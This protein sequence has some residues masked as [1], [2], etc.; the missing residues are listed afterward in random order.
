[1]QT[2]RIGLECVAIAAAIWAALFVVG[3]PVWSLLVGRTARLS[4]TT[5]APLTGLALVEAI[6][7]YWSHAFTLDPLAYA[8]VGAGAIASVV[9]A[10]RRRVWERVDRAFLV[11]VTAPFMG[12]A[13][14]VSALFVL[15]HRKVFRLGFLSTGVLGVESDLPNYA[16]WA[17]HLRHATIHQTGRV[18]GLDLGES[19]ASTT[20]G[21]FVAL[22]A[23]SAWSA[24]AP[25]Q[26]TLP[27]ALVM[28]FL[29]ACAARDLVAIVLPARRDRVVPTII[30]LAAVGASLYVYSG[31]QYP[32]SQLVGTAGM[33][34]ATAVLARLARTDEGSVVR[35]ALEVAP[36]VVVV[37][38]SYPHVALVG[39]PIVGGI[40][41]AGAWGGSWRHRATRVL[42]AGAGAA[43]ICVAVLPERVAHAVDYARALSKGV[44]AGFP[45]P[46]ISPLGLMFQDEFAYQTVTSDA[47]FAVEA[48]GFAVLL[49]AAV[50][51]A[52]RRDRGGALVA[53]AAAAALVASYAVV[54]AD[55]GASYTAWKWPSFFL[56]LLVVGASGA[57]AFVIARVVGSRWS[58]PATVGVLAAIVAMQAVAAYRA[59]DE[60]LPY[61]A[62]VPLSDWRVVD[63]QLR[64]L[65]DGP[66][67]HGI[68]RVTI[69]LLRV[70]DSQWAI[71]FVPTHRVAL[72]GVVVGK[73][74]SP[75]GGWRLEDRSRPPPHPPGTEYRIVNDRFW[76]ARES[77]KG[78]APGTLWEVGNCAGLYRFDGRRWSAVE[79]TP[80]TGGWRLSV[81]AKPQPAGTRAPLLVRETSTTRGSGDALVL[82]YV[83]RRRVR[84]DLVTAFLEPHVHKIGRSFP[85]PDGA[86]RIDAVFD[87]LTGEAR[88]RV[89]GRSVLATRVR[90]IRPRYGATAIGLNR[91]FGLPLVSKFPG[92]IRLEPVVRS[93]CL[94]ARAAG[95]VH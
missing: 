38:L 26:A 88:A 81:R 2:I 78:V 56:P 93:K 76:L 10:V 90:F 50:L 79:R 47:L 37:L 68:D 86:F 9:L 74:P 42:G 51:L 95:T 27:F 62:N 33:V 4:P 6:G 67:W 20:A 87:P 57:I 84:L 15:D 32:L 25:W 46:L 8:L 44:G 3:W 13:G 77:H 5:G 7:W 1:M 49:C 65:R 71:D 92:L 40:A 89:D 29:T 23:G 14:A 91:L 41:L 55:R 31:A 48:L 52:R 54:Y 28:T 53:A 24:T 35:S 63:E 58:V 22:A 21:T 18:L 17:D 30:G 43:V 19:I 64:T 59:T 82:D 39:T 83:R 73:L 11:R 69:D 12:L 34:A 61:A 85:L 36:A 45:L 70:W 60:F 75:R 94:A 80:Q 72:D 16:R 66:A